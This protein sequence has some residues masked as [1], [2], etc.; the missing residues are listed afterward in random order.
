V[1]YA[2]KFWEKF[3]RFLFYAPYKNGGSYVFVVASPI[4]FAIFGGVMKN[5][6]KN[7]D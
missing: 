2:K 7:M 5:G 3:Y 4:F 1:S 6:K